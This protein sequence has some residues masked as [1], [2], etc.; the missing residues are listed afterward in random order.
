M[1]GQDWLNLLKLHRV[2]AV[3]RTDSVATGLA[4]AKAVADG[5][6]RLIEATWN[7]DRP[8]AL[9]DAIRTE[10][11]HCTIG[12]GTLLNRDHIKDAI[13]A[14]AEYG[15]MP[16]VDTALIGYGRD[17]DWPIHPGALTPTEM[18]TAWN[19][20]ASGVK[21]FP[22]AAL[23]GCDYIRSLQGPLPHIPLIP[24]GGVTL[25]NAKDFLAAGAIAVGL[26]GELFPQSAILRQDWEAIT[27]RS[28]Q[29]ARAINAQIGT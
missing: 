1:P 7:S 19:A 17:R 15:F 11:P 20:G 22:V 25:D 26:A 3:I 2:I 18:M 13:A 10:L 28:Q 14:G 9:I 5:G 27:R 16:H 6:I 12:C 23:G 29:L 8:A 21:V 4:M 24:T